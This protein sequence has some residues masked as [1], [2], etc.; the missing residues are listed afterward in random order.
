MNEGGILCASH[1]Y[2]T[3]IATVSY[4]YL[5]KYIYIHLKGRPLLS[6][7]AGIDIALCAPKL[8]ANVCS[9]QEPIPSRISDECLSSIV[10]ASLLDKGNVFA[11]CCCSSEPLLL[12]RH[13]VKCSEAPQYV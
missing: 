2:N 6:V 3:L 1:A 12:A 10:R 9:R 4:R 11:V 13:I 7:P 8:L 5:D